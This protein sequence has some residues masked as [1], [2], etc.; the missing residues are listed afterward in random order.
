[1]RGYKKSLQK[2]RDK[3]SKKVFRM[4]KCHAKRNCETLNEC[5]VEISVP[6]LMLSEVIKIIVIERTLGRRKQTISVKF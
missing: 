5:D 3:K 4:S 6:H 2:I 1:M